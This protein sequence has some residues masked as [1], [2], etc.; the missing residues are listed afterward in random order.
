MATP[1]G[2]KD[3]KAGK[4]VRV[5]FRRNRAPA[6][7]L[8]GWTEKARQAEGH[9]IDSVR[10]EQIA[11][12]GALSR[13]RTV[14]A[15]DDDSLAEG[16]QLGIVVAMRGLYAEVDDGENVWPCTVRRVLRTR[17]IKERHP[18]TV[19]DRVHF[20]IEADAEG[21]VREGVIESVEARRGKLQRLSGRRIQTIVAN[22]DQVVIVSSAAEPRPRVH[23]IDRYIVA[24]LAG[25]VT[26]VICMNKIDLD[27]DG[28]TKSMLNRYIKLG[29]TTLR[30]SAV[31]D[32]GIDELREVLRDKATGVAGQSGVGKSSLL[33]A[34]QPG[35]K[36][37]VG[38]IVEQTG[39]GRHTT[40]TARL[41]RLDV[42]GF[43]VDTPGIRSCDV[44]I[45]KRHE[46]EVYFTEFV[47]HLSGCK[48]P[49]CSHTHEIEC[50]VKSAVESGK[51][52]AERYETYLELF[53]EA[54]W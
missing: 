2:K 30:T 40:T 43:V 3:S 27:A 15:R 20:A 28:V 25:E 38:D 29:Y 31:T 41:L 33:N 12:R 4:K 49:D 23:L 42:G 46:L 7:R 39:K 18:V 5:H 26:P 35:L 1:P 54:P 14:I 51:I 8:K 16:L 6:P 47:D 24:A 9:E 11:A 22:V 17:L 32:Q 48:F 13:R 37:R 10:S 21:V 50:A 36:L 19:G 45:I 34:I 44:S 53:E 52:H